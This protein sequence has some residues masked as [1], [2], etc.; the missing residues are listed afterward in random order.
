MAFIQKFD[1]MLDLVLDIGSDLTFDLR[2]VSLASATLAL[3]GSLQAE[4]LPEL[5]IDPAQVS[6]SGLSAGGFMAV[7]LH[8][9]YSSTFK[10]GAGVV[11]GGPYYC[12]E[13]SIVNATGRCMTHSGPIPVQSLIDITRSWAASRAL[14]P[15][16]NLRSSKVYLFSGSRDSVVRPAVM[17]DL[18]AFYRKLVPAE[19]IVYRKDV[20]AEH[21]FVT[22][23][24][25]NAC[26]TKGSPYINKCGF[27]LAG[28]ILKHLHGPLKPRSSEAAA[29]RYIEF[30]QTPYVRGHGMAS[31]GWVYVPQ[32]CT[33][34]ASCKLHVA[35]H[36]CVQNTG[37]VNQQF[38]RETGYNRWADTNDIV[39]LYPQTGP[40]ATNG[41]FDWWGYD[42]PDYAKKN[43]PQMAGIKAMVD[44]LGG[45]DPASSLAPP[46]SVST[47]GATD[48]TMTIS[49]TAVEGAAGYHVQRGGS[50]VTSEPVTD[51]RYT[52]TGLSPGTAYQWTVRSVDASGAESEPS[53]AATGKTTGATASCTTANNFAH[54]A[55]GRAYQRHGF[56]YAKGSDQ[57]IG[58]WNFFIVTTLKQTGP[59]HYVLGTC[60]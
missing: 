27:D 23:Q 31:T 37:A 50:R 34:G 7:Q 4:P 28:E 24:Y 32:S 38:I 21:A 56:A 49:W 55:A 45:G 22:E 58:L 12:A 11:A 46:S 30:D 54:V 8:L 5:R 52:D 15:L 17:D 2:R 33:A 35:L 41:C 60:S 19:Q 36:G 51:T 13:N 59:G 1:H 26:A 44:R 16:E 53:A 40:G 47:S 43:G 57:N 29:G 20:P 10:K 39:V 42:S 6:V 25:G 48:T 3:A 18:D 9:A 14:D